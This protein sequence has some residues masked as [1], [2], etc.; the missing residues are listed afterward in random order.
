MQKPEAALALAAGDHEFRPPAIP[1][2]L[3]R[4]RRLRGGARLVSPGKGTEPKLSNRTFQ[5]G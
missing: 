2:G 3:Q 4:H 1:T 5:Y